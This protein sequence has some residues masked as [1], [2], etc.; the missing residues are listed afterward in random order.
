MYERIRKLQSSTI[1]RYFPAK[2]TQKLPMALIFI[3]LLLLGYVSAE[4]G[5]MF[6]G[7]H[8]LVRQWEAQ[9]QRATTPNDGKQSVVVD[10]GLTR[11]TIP[12][13]D[14]S[15][16]VVEGTT[17]HSLLLG[18]GH[19]KSTAAP[20]ESGNSVITGHRD[21]FFR[22]IYELTKGDELVV[23]RSGKIFK[24]QVTGKKIVQPTDVSVIEP[25]SEPRLTL[26]TCYPTYYIGPAPERLVV[27]SKLIEGD[28][29]PRPLNQ[30]VKATTLPGDTSSEAETAH[31]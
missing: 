24:Y 11:L 5:Q 1:S 20:G 13:I 4:Y 8:R 25:S 30:Q 12:K 28:A 26:I 16:V 14:F 3:G 2:Y 9:Q 7:Q 6:W 17:R 10:D 21:T 22:H 27:F 31:E 19:I 23:E 15:A 29:I 18:P